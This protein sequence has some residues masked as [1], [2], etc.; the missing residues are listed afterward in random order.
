MALKIYL[1]QLRLVRLLPQ[2]TN[3]MKALMFRSNMM[4]YWLLPVMEQ[5]GLSF[6][7]SS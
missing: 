5:K 3:S 2:F 4:K 6:A 7:M 1:L